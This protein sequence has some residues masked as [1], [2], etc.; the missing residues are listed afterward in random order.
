MPKFTM[1]EL[2]RTESPKDKKGT[3]IIWD[4]QVQGFGLR[5]HPTNSKS[6][7]IQYRCGSKQRFMTIGQF[8]KV[9]LVKARNVAKEK[10][11][12]IAGGV[13]PIEQKK[14]NKERLLTIEQLC[15]YYMAEYAKPRKKSWKEDGRRINSHVLPRTGK[16]AALSLKRSDIMK[17]HREI[18]IKSP[19]EANRILALLS[20]L[21]EFGRGADY[22]PETHI[23]PCRDVEKY[24]EKPR[25]RWLSD[26]DEFLKLLNAISEDP[27]IYYRSFFTLLILTG[28]RKGEL[29]NLK[30][31]QIDFK[32]SSVYF[33]DTKSGYSETKPLSDHSI[34]VLN[35]IPRLVDNLFVFPSPTKVG[36]PSVNMDIPWR[37]IKKRAGID[38]L[39]IHDLRRTFVS[40][41]AN[42]KIPLEIAS[43]AIGHRS[44]RVTETVYARFKDDPIREAINQTGDKIIS[45]QK[46]KQEK[47][48]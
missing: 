47:S 11:G 36:Q 41:M 9:S 24:K 17:K 14:K 5:I 12:D 40:Y 29:Q 25:E 37:R 43:K 19:Y 28:M 21:F 22:L 32:K 48:A 20:K 31:S 4:D 2:L 18:G 42:D 8:P 1:K 33:A 3:Y 7:I 13:D 34:R 10:F 44:I 6:W 45:L 46:I 39:R 26:G 16:R 38:D 27:N 15:I 23:N 35:E 30:W